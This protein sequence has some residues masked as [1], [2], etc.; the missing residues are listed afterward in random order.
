MVHWV[1]NLTSV[2][3]VIVEVWVQSLTWELPYASSAAIKRK[4]KKKKKVAWKAGWLFQEQLSVL[5]LSHPQ[6]A[7]SVLRVTPLEKGVATVL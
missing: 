1:K 4:T 5:L 3:L 7:S 6:D 2:A